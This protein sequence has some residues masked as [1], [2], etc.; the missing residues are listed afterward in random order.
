MS[1]GLVRL[2]KITPGFSAVHVL[3][4]VKATSCVCIPPVRV[5]YVPRVFATGEAPNGWCLFESFALST[6]SCRSCLHRGHA[7]T[8]DDLRFFRGLCDPCAPTRKL[9]GVAVCMHVSHPWGALT[10]LACIAFGLCSELGVNEGVG[11]FRVSLSCMPL[12]AGF[13]TPQGPASFCSRVVAAAYHPRS[14]AVP[15]CTVS[16]GTH[17]FVGPLPTPGMVGVHPELGTLHQLRFLEPRSFRAGGIHNHLPVWEKHLDGQSSS[18]VDLLG[19]VRDGVRIERFFKHFK[20][21]FGGLV[22]DS[23]TP[24]PMQLGNAKVCERHHDFI[25]AT[26]PD[27]VSAGVLSVWRSWVTWTSRI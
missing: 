16:L 24:P 21:N 25:T 12:S 23:E 9:P 3:P 14:D 1:R 19:I 22:Y 27:W 20:G 13:P 6:V 18:P 10:N 8:G 15:L 17:P 7:G 11:P 4:H 5:A 26:I 2:E